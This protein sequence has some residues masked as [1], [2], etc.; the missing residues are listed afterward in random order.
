[1]NGGIKRLEVQLE[2]SGAQLPGQKNLVSIK[3]IG[4]KAAAILLA[5]IGK[6]EDF[7]S[8]A[9]LANYFG[10]V[11]RVIKFLGLVNDL[12]ARRAAGYLD[13]SQKPAICL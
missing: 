9:K 4:P 13:I 8:E 7:D 10:I 12:R 11:P 3:G 5:V 1:M 6:V 2:A